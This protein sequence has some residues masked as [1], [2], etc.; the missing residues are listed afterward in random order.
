LCGLAEVVL[1]L[2][3][4]TGAHKTQAATVQLEQNGAVG[5][6]NQIVVQVTLTTDT[7]AINA[8]EGSI[9]VPDGVRIDGLDT[10]GSAFPLWVEYPELIVADSKITFSGGV[11]RGITQDTNALLFTIR[12]HA[13]VPGSYPFVV[14]YADAYRSDGK[15]T[16]EETRL[17]G[18]SVAVDESDGFNKIAKGTETTALVVDVGQDETLFGGRTFISFY[19]GDAGSGVAY[20]EVREGWWRATERAERYYVLKDQKQSSAV[21]VTAVSTD[22]TKTT[23]V[24]PSAHPNLLPIVALILVLL[25]LVA[26]VIARRRAVRSKKI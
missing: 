22:G 7:A 19:G 14:E 5:A 8:V 10:A 20:Y 25:V 9:Q 21:R 16:K 11:P 15:G 3:S 12:A 24:L 26:L 6:G 4:L 23:V 13:D 18:V 2:L 17:D 1:I